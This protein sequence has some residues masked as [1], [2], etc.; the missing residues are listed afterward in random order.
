[1]RRAP[2]FYRLLL[3]LLPRSLRDKHG[4]DMELTLLEALDEEGGRGGVRF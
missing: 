1:M 4:P 3:R 2:L